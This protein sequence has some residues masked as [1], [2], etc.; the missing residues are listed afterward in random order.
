MGRV[1]GNWHREPATIQSCV[2]T[3]NVNIEVEPYPGETPSSLLSRSLIE[4]N[5][6]QVYIYVNVLLI[7]T[8][9]FVCMPA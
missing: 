7:I 8:T 1:I 3:V 9:V 2:C 5:S 6:F 4:K